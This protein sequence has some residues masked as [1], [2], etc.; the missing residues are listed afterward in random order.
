MEERIDLAL[1]LRGTGDSFR[2]AQYPNPV[3]EHRSAEA[4]CWT[5]EEAERTAAVFRFLL[6]RAQIRLA[7]GRINFRDRG[8]RMLH[9]GVNA[10]ITGDML[11]TAGITAKQDT[12]MIWSCGFRL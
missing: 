12:E 10:A 1:T 7:G 11:T 6:P 4:R 8:R 3:G 2:S 5:G 9:S